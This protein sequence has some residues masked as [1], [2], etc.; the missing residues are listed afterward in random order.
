LLVDGRDPQLFE[1][2]KREFDTPE[3]RMIWKEQVVMQEV[4]GHTEQALTLI[5]RMSRALSG[6]RI[7]QCKQPN[8]RKSVGNA[9]SY[10][11]HL[12]NIASEEHSGARAM[13]ARSIDETTGRFPNAG[14]T[15]RRQWT[16]CTLACGT[17]I[18]MANM[19]MQSLQCEH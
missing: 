14:N 18:D 3:S 19:L 9:T 10:H 11:R 5:A 13:F 2:R 16:D 6:V 1:Q 4:A 7:R 12:H 17:R 8:R 15:G